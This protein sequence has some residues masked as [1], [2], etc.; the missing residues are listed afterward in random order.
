MNRRGFLKIAAAAPVLVVAPKF[1][2]AGVPVLARY[3]HQTV[4]LGFGLA[5][6]KAEGAAIAYD[7]VGGM[8]SRAAFRAQLAAGLNEVFSREYDKAALNGEWKEV[9]GGDVDDFSKESDEL[10][11]GLLHAG[12]RD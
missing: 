8:L 2:T 6:V 9:F 7:G 3:T 10:D 11:V 5:P 12:D 1:F 4:A